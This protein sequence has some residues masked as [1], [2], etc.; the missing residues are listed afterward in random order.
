[1]DLCQPLKSEFKYIRRGEVKSAR[2]DY[3]GVLES[4]FG[5]GLADHK[6]DV[7]PKMEKN[8]GIK[9]E[10]KNSKLSG[11]TGE[12]ENTV[13]K[14]QSKR[15]LDAWIEVQPKRR[16]RP[17]GSKPGFNPG[18]GNSNLGRNSG[19][20]GPSKNEKDDKYDSLKVTTNENVGNNSLE[21]ISK[22]I[23]EVDKVQVQ[24]EQ[25]QD[26]VIKETANENEDKE[27][28]VNMETDGGGPILG[29][30]GRVKG[31]AL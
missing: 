3:E 17:L 27:N 28:V 13:G 16:T 19:Q 20:G 24:E 12:L 29:K 1:M 25:P 14:E 4:C 22:V 18:K 23:A 9:I 30:R 31:S 21:K 7:C 15:D 26:Y 11:P 8:I 5:C 6:A 10:K 2:I